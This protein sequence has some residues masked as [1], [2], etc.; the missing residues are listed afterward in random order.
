MC[1]RESVGERDRKGGGWKGTGL[2]GTG[3]GGEHG[4]SVVFDV[5]WRLKLDFPPSQPAQRAGIS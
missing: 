3:W 1:V 4:S 2:D 5:G